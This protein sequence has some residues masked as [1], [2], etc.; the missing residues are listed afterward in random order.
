MKDQFE[1]NF[2]INQLIS[3]Q[4]HSYTP[5][6]VEKHEN[7]ERKSPKI[8]NYHTIESSTP[9]ESYKYYE[10]DRRMHRML[11]PSLLSAEN[12]MQLAGRNILSK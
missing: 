9:Q 3:Q 7:P 11:Q 1:K 6:S 2:H 8:Q 12:T 5:G 4:S 10:G